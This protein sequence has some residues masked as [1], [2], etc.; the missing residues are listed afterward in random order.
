MTCHDFQLQLSL[1]LYGELDFAAEDELESH[2]AECAFCQQAFAREKTWHSAASSEQRG[3][4]L[5]LLAR[6]REDLHSSI[7]AAS[8]PRPIPAGRWR[9]WLSFLQVRPTRWSYQLALGSLLVFAGFLSGRFLNPQGPLLDDIATSNAG[10]LGS[11]RIRDI[12]PNGPGRVRI[13]YEQ[14]NQREVVGSPGD[15]KSFLLIAMRDPADPSLRVDSLDMLSGQTGADVRTVLIHCIEHDTNAAVRLKALQTFRSASQDPAIRKVLLSVLEHDADP[16]VRSEAINLL[17][18]VGS[19]LQYSPELV[20]SLQTLVRSEQ[21]DYLRS[22]YVQLLLAM[23][24]PVD[25]Y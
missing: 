15:V 17:A 7:S 24:A 11:T 12:Q 20:S 4:P 5:D 22:R 25:S 14:V 10:L 18:P 3:V 2:L 19:Q 16:A 13:V 21:D 8:A 6:C 23:G 9:D 1:Y